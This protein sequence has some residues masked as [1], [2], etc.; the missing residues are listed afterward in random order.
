MAFGVQTALAA[1]GV[2][3]PL[4]QALGLVVLPVIVVLAFVGHPLNR[5]LWVVWVVVILDLL[6]GAWIGGAGGVLVAF[7]E[8][9]GVSL[10]W[11]FVS[12]FMRGWKAKD[13]PL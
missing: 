4:R 6:C 9:M 10:V 3:R 12:S 11:I 8:L 5:K 2:P 7:L 1:L 13:S